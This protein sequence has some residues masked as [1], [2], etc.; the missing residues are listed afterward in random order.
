M[1][2][3]VIF[4]FDGII[5]DSEPFHYRA[6]RSVLDSLGRKLAWQEYCQGY[7]GLDDRDAFKKAL[8]TENQR[9]TNTELECLIGKKTIAF[10]KR[11]R[12]EKITPFPGVMDLIGNLASQVPIA[13]CSGGLKRDILPII[14]QLGIGNAFEHIVT[15]ED[16]EKSKPDPAPYLLTI[17]KLGLADAGTAVAIEDSAAGIRSARAAGLKVLAV[18]N[19]HHRKQLHESDAQTDSLKEITL[20]SLENMFF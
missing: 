13:L 4:D 7:L 3:A 5:V 19:S 17:S 6:F 15:A 20:V 8:T 2:N 12:A 16:T 9:I 10:Q 14:R 1:L 18:T 11:V